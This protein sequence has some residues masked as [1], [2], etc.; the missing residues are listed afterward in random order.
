MYT[1]TV[2]HISSFAVIAIACKRKA[3]A[4]QCNFISG[5]MFIFAIHKQPKQT[6]KQTKKNNKKKNYGMVQYRWW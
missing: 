3:G 6:N 2:A 5:A 1:F 4:M